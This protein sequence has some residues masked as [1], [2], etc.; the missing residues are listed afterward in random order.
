MSRA[1]MGAMQRSAGT[2]LLA[3]ALA[4]LVPGRAARAEEPPPAPPAEP[5]KRP[6]HPEPRVIVN[7][8]SVQGPHPRSDVERSARLGWGRIVSC[9]NAYGDRRRLTVSLELAVS[10]SGKVTAF[11]PIRS[12]HK[13]RDLAQCLGHAMKRLSMP[14]ARARSIAIAEIQLGPGDSA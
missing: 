11:R 14:K 8:T 5:G 12:T 4:L 10:S 7:V 2:G 9:Y 1:K 3:A 13:N 6:A